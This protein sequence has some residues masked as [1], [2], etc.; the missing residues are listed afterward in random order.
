LAGIALVVLGSTAL[1]CGGG[2]TSTPP[3]PV[4]IPSA[5][6]TEASPSG[7]TIADALRALGDGDD[8]AAVEALRTIVA[9]EP[10]SVDAWL[11]LAQL[12]MAHDDYGAALTVL[13][14]ARCAVREADRWQVHVVRA[15]A[16]MHMNRFD[17]ASEELEVMRGQHGAVAGSALGGKPDTHWLL[18][19]HSWIHVERRERE[20]AR[21]H[22]R[23]Y[24]ARA[25]VDGAEG[26]RCE[27]VRRLDACLAE[28]HSACPVNRA[29]VDFS[30]P[31]ESVPPPV[32]CD[33]A[34]LPAIALQPIAPRSLR[35][36]TRRWRLLGLRHE[37]RDQSVS[38]EAYVGGTTR[39]VN[40]GATPETSLQLWPAPNDH[41][42][43]VPAMNAKHDEALSALSKGAT[44]RIT[45][46]I[47]WL[48]KGSTGLF[49]SPRSGMLIPE[50][51]EV[52]TD[53]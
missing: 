44:V 34:A 12:A 32:D 40:D 49:F 36:L 24:L 43:T 42:V 50:H 46:N 13:G 9:R 48:H 33:A 17:L 3:P 26:H 21:S 29:I 31:G 19:L 51:I 22:A 7:P 1:G 37:L 45:G 11:L 23:G 41:S 52:L 4:V 39:V 38:V 15:I 14:T 35:T 6:A 16:L 25:C 20:Q 28:P 10:Q 8:A 30:P 18:W 27:D 47:D 2:R 5:R 53:E